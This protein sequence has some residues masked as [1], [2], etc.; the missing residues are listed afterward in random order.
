[1]VKNVNHPTTRTPAPTV[2]SYVARSFTARVRSW[3]PLVLRALLGLLLWTAAW[4]AIHEATATA[5]VAA[6]AAI[7]FWFGWLFVFALFAFLAFVLVTGVV[8]DVR[9]PILA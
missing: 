7:G 9:D 2:R 3:T 8:K 6:L 1:M 5:Q 4:Y